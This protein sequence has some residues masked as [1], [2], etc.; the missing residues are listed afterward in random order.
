[1]LTI[2]SLKAI[3]MQRFYNSLENENVSAN[4][5]KIIHNIIKPFLHFIYINGLNIRDLSI[6]GTV[7]LPKVIKSNDKQTVLSLDDQQK[8]ID[9]LTATN[10]SDRIIFI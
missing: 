5:I 1:M 10:N 8:F 6:S 3:D 7:K 9:Y 2:Q 4:T